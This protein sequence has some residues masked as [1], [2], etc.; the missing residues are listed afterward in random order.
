MVS[1]FISF[2]AAQVLFGY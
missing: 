1:V 2:A